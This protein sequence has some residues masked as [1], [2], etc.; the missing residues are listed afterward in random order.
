[1]GNQAPRNDFAGA[2][3]WDGEKG[4]V[5]VEDE[6][7][8]IFIVAAVTIDF[9]GSQDFWNSRSETLGYEDEF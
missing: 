3:F 9:V 8:A 5:E 1:L 2:I 4:E 6:E 7:G